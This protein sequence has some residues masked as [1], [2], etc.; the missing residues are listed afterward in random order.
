MMVELAKADP[1]EA[2]DR[3]PAP[4]LRAWLPGRHI[5][6]L[7]VLCIAFAPV[8]WMTLLQVGGFSLEPFHFPLIILTVHTVA[9]PR[10]YLAIVSALHLNISWLLPF[11]VYILPLFI[12]FIVVVGSIF[13]KIAAPTEAAALG[14]LAALGACYF[15]KVFNKIITITGIEG[16]IRQYRNIQDDCLRIVHLRCTKCLP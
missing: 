11:F 4:I 3:Y 5:D 6:L 9:R 1:A 15:F 8:Q 2:A 16:V 14:C 7:L 12:I 13:F 10:F